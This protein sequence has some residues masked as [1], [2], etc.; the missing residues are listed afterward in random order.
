MKRLRLV[1]HPARGATLHQLL[2]DQRYRVVAVL[3]RSRRGVSRDKSGT[4]RLV[5]AQNAESGG[6]LWVVKLAP[7][8]GYSGTVAVE[9]I[10]ETWNTT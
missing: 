2:V 10:P 6:G 9:D 1:L 8:T 5:S 4:A 7:R 3:K